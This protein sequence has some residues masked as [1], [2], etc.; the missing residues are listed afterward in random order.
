MTGTTIID[1]LVVPASLDVPEAADLLAMIDV[2]NAVSHDAMGAA[3]DIIAPVEMLASLQDQ[4]Y[5]RKHLY[6]ARLN[7]N[8]VGWAGVIWG[9]EYD[10]RVTWVDLGVHPDFRNQGV[11]T[12]LFEHVERLAQEADRPVIQGMGSYRAAHDGPRLDSPTGFGSLPKADPGVRFLQNRGYSLEQ[13]YR[14]SVLNLP[15]PEATLAEH[16]TAA[17]ERAGSDYRVHTWVAPTPERWLDDMAVILTRMSTDAP[18]GNLDIDEEPWDAE[19]IRHHDE[20]RKR[21]GRTAIAAVVEHIPSGKLVA[22]NG[23][24]LPKDRNR[25]VHQGVTLVLKEHRGHRLGMV[26]KIANIQQLQAISPESPLIV[27]DNAEENRPMLDVNEAVGFVP[28]AYVGAW[29]K[30]FA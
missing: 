29:K 5:Q 27:T 18:S 17:Q 1:A 7:G 13:V 14:V 24:S 30:T 23:L 6:L 28:A 12:A 8:I 11:G 2:M 3:A 21:T 15:I 26:T 4:Q 9:V 16:L 10:L 19:R 25:P 20:L 22:Y